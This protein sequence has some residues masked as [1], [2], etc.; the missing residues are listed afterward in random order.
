MPQQRR[1]R[2]LVIDDDEVDRELVERGLAAC[3]LAVEPRLTGSI[4]TGLSAIADEAWDCVFV[5]LRFPEGDAFSLF[6]D[7]LGQ[8]CARRPPLV[9]LTGYGG[10]QVAV[11]AMKRGVQDYLPKSDIRPDTLRRV[12][13]GA[14]A[15]SA[16]ALELEA[17]QA[18]LQRRSFEDELT[19]LANRPLFLDR[20]DQRL[21]EASRTGQPF[22][23]L[24]MDLDGFKAINDS[25]GHAAGDEVLR[26]VATRLREQVRQSDTVARLG[27]DEFAVLLACTA[28]VDGAE[29]V[30][31]KIRQAIAE[32][33]TVTDSVVDIGTSLG[34]ALFPGHGVDAAGLLHAADLAMYRAKRHGG[35]WAVYDPAVEANAAGVTPIE[36]TA[37]TEPGLPDFEL[38]YQPLVELASGRVV[39]VEALPCWQ[40]PELGLLP[41]MDLFPATER[42][43]LRTLTLRLIERAMAD[44]GGWP[45][46]DGEPLSMAVNLPPALLRDTTL[47]ADIEGCL[48]RH[49]I[50]P[51]RL[52]LEISESRP[53]GLL[54]R[55]CGELARLH[56]I[57]VRLC[58]DDFGTGFTPAPRLC[59]WPVD[60]IKLERL[61]VAG[62]A[63]NVRHAA[64]VRSMVEFGQET[65]LRVIAQGVD[66]DEFEA[67]L[68]AVGCTHAQGLRLGA[69]LTAERLLGGAHARRQGE[70]PLAADGAH[71]GSQAERTGL[72]AE[73]AGG[74]R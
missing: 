23:L 73:A 65:G 3:G 53:F 17:R 64:V 26:T 58:I 27:G 47:A 34:I 52:T 69:A 13:E 51:G 30:A 5:D 35:G 42:S 48:S 43:G 72:L 7:L 66:N 18:E 28:Q 46:V 67:L 9:L 40:H 54:A 71:P 8:S 36:A 2:V 59:E 44:L 31:E 62:M 68:G 63:G 11:E 20:L 37:R 70:T 50:A 22:A 49:G 10:E 25:F 74:R 57:G 14:M 19:G 21:R 33:I 16:A 6:G 61:L 4:R 12:L 56:E 24:M 39:G 41:P 45:A 29:V 32:P 38:R 15:Q 60:E 1:Y 55:L